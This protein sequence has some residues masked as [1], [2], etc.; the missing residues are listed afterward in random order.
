MPSVDWKL[1]ETWMVLVLLT[2][3]SNCLF[4]GCSINIFLVNVDLIL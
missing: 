2:A 3:A 1:H 4:A